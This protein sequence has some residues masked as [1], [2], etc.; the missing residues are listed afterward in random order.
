MLVDEPEEDEAEVNVEKEQD[1]VSPDI[2]Q[3]L[4]DI[5]Y[6]LETEKAASEE[7]DKEDK[8][9]SSSS[10]S[11]IDETERLKRIQAEIEKV[12]QLNRKRREEKDDDLY[13]PSLEHV[14]E[15]QTPPSSGGRKKSNARKRVVSPKAARR[16]LTIKLNPKRASKPKPPSPPPS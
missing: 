2:E 10:E 1:P 15:S 14:Q 5:D 13:N 3:V 7:S 9:S 11:E 6:E 12:K 8:S 16:K 4:K